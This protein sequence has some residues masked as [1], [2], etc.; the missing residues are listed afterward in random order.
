MSIGG[1]NTPATAGT[2]TFSNGLFT[3]SGNHTY[4]APGSLQTS[5]QINHDTAP[6][7]TVS[8]TVTIQTLAVTPPASQTATEGA[9]NAFNLGSFTDPNSNATSW[10]VA[11]QWGDG[12][13][14]TFTTTSQ[15]TLTTQAH[16]YAEEGSYTVTLTV[17]DNTNLSGSATFQ[18]TVADPAVSAT[19][20]GLSAVEGAAFSNQ[21]VATF[22]DPAG[23]EATADYSATINWGDN[24]AASTG[25]IS[26]SNGTFTVS[27][28]H[29]Y[30]EEGTY[31]ITVT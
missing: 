2:I 4:T 20:T 18:V 6:S 14:T 30:A 3:V 16:T 26:F 23:A 5:V 10:T 25:A 27:G 8:G 7:A 17:T 11:V 9:S 31:P 12:A 28:D 15:G 19:A 22:T 29:T 21:A 13:A 24:A 1:H